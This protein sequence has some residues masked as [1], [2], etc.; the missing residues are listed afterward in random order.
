MTVRAKTRPQ[1]PEADDAD[2]GPTG[3]MPERR[4]IVTRQVRPV[5]E[6]IRFV[7]GPDGVVVPDIRRRLPGRGVWVTAHRRTVDEAARKGLFARALKARATAPADLA[8]QVAGRLKDAAL[9]A[10]GLERK[11]GR[12][13]LGFT[14]VEALLRQGD[15]A[16]VIHA[17][18]AKPDGVRKLDQAAHSGGRRPATCRAFTL[19]ELGLALGRENVIH[20]ALERA[21]GGE[22]AAE[23]C[24]AYER[25]RTERGGESSGGGHDS[26]DGTNE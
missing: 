9:G 24:R 20:A 16:L 17:A 19:A 21:R 15:A 12:L 8:E 11:A 2:D 14:D 22:A 25:Y 3:R 26:Q 13:K 23:R 7:A 18:E 6:L 5:E 4:C 1:A 10:L